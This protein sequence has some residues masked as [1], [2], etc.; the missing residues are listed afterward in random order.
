MSEQLQL[1][2]QPESMM[3][4]EEL[5]QRSDKI[6]HIYTQI[7]SELNN[8]NEQ[9]NNEPLSEEDSQLY[10]AAISGVDQAL[11]AVENGQPIENPALQLKRDWSDGSSLHAE[12]QK[13]HLESLGDALV[14]RSTQSEISE[15]VAIETEAK[16]Q[17]DQAEVQAR[18]ERIDTHNEKINARNETLDERAETKAKYLSRQRLL[19]GENHTKL[20][21]EELNS[22]A[23]AHV[24]EVHGELVRDDVLDTATLPNKST[25]RQERVAELSKAVKDFHKSASPEASYKRMQEKVD[26]QVDPELAEN[27]MTA[28]KALDMP[29]DIIK[30]IPASFFYNNATEGVTTDVPDSVQLW[31]AEDSSRI[32][33]L[34]NLMQPNNSEPANIEPLPQTAVEPSPENDPE[35]AKQLIE[36]LGFMVGQT[37]K[38]MR[39]NSKEINE[40]TLI[41][42]AYEGPDGPVFVLETTIETENGTEKMKVTSNTDSILSMTQAAD[43]YMTSFRRKRIKGQTEDAH[44]DVLY[45]EGARVRNAI[46]RE[47]KEQYSLSARMGA[48]MS[49]RALTLREKLQSK[50]GKR[51]AAYVGSAAV[52]MTV[53]AYVSSKYGIPLL[54]G[55]PAQAEAIDEIKQIDM[56]AAE[57]LISEVETTE[58]SAEVS[59]E[60]TADAET[61]AV[62]EL[63]A[64]EF[65]VSSG[66]GFT[67]LFDRLAN[68]RGYDLSPGQLYEIYSQ[69]P[70]LDSVD[71]VYTMPNGDLGIDAKSISLSPEQIEQFEKLLKDT[72]Q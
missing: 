21:A 13:A 17:R 40:D 52:G 26:P 45:E 27:W 30:E 19:K 35:R 49:T 55:S 57:N 11:E 68:N 60:T 28:F 64:R 65:K 38:T 71:G 8:D 14:A 20:F 1:P 53:L 18:Q 10:E 58:Q 43:K 4:P 61:P 66:E 51:R 47:H 39:G 24:N 36:S 72:K 37:V 32:R 2:I 44:A 16:Q 50:D 22:E 6:N 3:T 9:Q 25:A 62:Q 15:K 59:A 41:I 69:I 70:N 31:L 63:E 54:D 48:W 56:S 42:D 5:D 23:D 46:R 67:Q 33:A 29:D 34:N 12:K 7:G